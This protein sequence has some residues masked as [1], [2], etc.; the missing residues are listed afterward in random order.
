MTNDV[1]RFAGEKMAVEFVVTTC[2]NH[3]SLRNC[4]AGAARGPL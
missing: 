1:P 4:N 2:E 3:A